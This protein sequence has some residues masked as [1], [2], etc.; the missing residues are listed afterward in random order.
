MSRIMDEIVEETKLEAAQNML[1]DGVP[2]DKIANWQ[3]LPLETV[4]QLA[5]QLKTEPVLQ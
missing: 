2:I 3:N 5:E 4:Q 1:L